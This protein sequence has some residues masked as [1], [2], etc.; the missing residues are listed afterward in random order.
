MA[1]RIDYTERQYRIRF[2]RKLILR[3]VLATTASYTGWKVYDGCRIYK[4]PNLDAKLS[5]YE[6]AAGTIERVNREWIEASK[7]YQAMLKYYRLVWADKPLEFLSAISKPTA[8]KPGPSFHP[9]QWTLVTGGECR[10]DYVCTFDDAVGMDKRVRVNSIAPELVGMVTACVK[11][12]VGEVAVKNVCYTNL[13]NMTRQ[14][15]YVTFTLADAKKFPDTNKSLAEHVGEIQAMRKKILTSKFAETDGSKAKQNLPV[16]AQELMTQYVLGIKDL[17]DLPPCTNVINVAG[18]LSRVDRIASPTNSMKGTETTRRALK[19]RWNR[20]GKAQLPWQRFRVL[21]ND[22]IVSRTRKLKKALGSVSELA[23]LLESRHEDIVRK[24]KPLVEAYSRNDVF[25]YPYIGNDLTNNVTRSV[26]VEP[27]AVW[28][29]EEPEKNPPQLVLNDERFVF[30]SVRWKLLLG[31][32]SMPDGD[33]VMRVERARPITL[34]DVSACAE[35]AVRLGPGYM[36]DKV[37]IR[38]DDEGQV[39]WAVLEGLL[40]VKEV[41]KI[42]GVKK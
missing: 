8:P 14:E 22:D 42:N 1:Y 37:V 35:R 32:D 5:D 24:L 19:A 40:P 18:W 27:V 34:A 2:W 33:R 38:F 12:V 28:F 21:D 4:Q 7:E 20:I 36:I 29:A 41:T 30:K 10:L 25:D 17:S 31:A 11:T 15:P 39:A 13:L 6:T 16:T 3:L 23:G 26:G 9:R